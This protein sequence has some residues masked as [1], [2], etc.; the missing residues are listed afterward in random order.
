MPVT[1]LRSHPTVLKIFALLEE[2]NSL[3][4]SASQH[5]L[6]EV[7]VTQVTHLLDEVLSWQR[8]HGRRA[9]QIARSLGA[10]AGFASETLHH[11]TL[12]AL[13]HDIGL[14]ALSSDLASHTGYLGIHSY[15]DR[16]C[17]PRLGAQWLEPYPFLR[18][19]AVIIA[20]HHERWD[21]SGY[22][23]GIRGSFI[24]I[25]ARVLAIADAFDA[26]EVPGVNDCHLR[27]HVAY[28]IIAAA[29]GTQFDPRLV[30][31]WHQA[32]IFRLAGA[33]RSSLAKDINSK[34]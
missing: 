27:D 2:V 21:G 25:E 16:Q 14:L 10:A 4:S 31:L 7:T 8:G 15:A 24:P 19:A 12:A 1:V 17:H 33:D 29:A 34:P 13:L 20:H 23:Y 18:Q 3:Q 9:A 11:L 32:G 30:E 22:P 26:I 28:R 5:Y 6:E